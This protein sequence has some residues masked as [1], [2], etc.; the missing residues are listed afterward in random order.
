MAGMWQQKGKKRQHSRC[1]KGVG[2]VSAGVEFDMVMC[3]I[4]LKFIEIHGLFSFL[5][6]LPTPCR[7]HFDTISTPPCFRLFVYSHTTNRGL[8]IV[9]R[10]PFE[11]FERDVKKNKM[12]SILS[13]KVNCVRIKANYD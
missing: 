4:M 6:T 5:P 7:H 8:G 10:H 1:R 9:F 12:Y 3:R 13:K 2:K 11:I